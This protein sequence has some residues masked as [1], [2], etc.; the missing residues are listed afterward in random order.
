M[1]T[2]TDVCVPVT[3]VCPLTGW[4]QYM[5]SPA[6]TGYLYAPPSTS[7]FTPLVVRSLIFD[8]ASSTVSNHVSEWYCGAD[9][10]SS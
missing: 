10:T 7:Y 6:A 1:S 9:A 8:F 4:Q 2:Y 3:D 5:S